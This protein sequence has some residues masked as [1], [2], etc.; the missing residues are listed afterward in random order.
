[1]HF[2]QMKI[3]GHSSPTQ[4]ASTYDAAP[5]SDLGDKSNFELRNGSGY[6]E[7]DF[8]PSYSVEPEEQESRGSISSL[9]KRNESDF[10]DY[11]FLEGRIADAHDD[12]ERSISQEQAGFSSSSV[13]LDEKRDSLEPT[14]TSQ[15]QARCSSPSVTWDEKRETLEPTRQDFDYDGMAQEDNHNRPLES[16]SPHLD[17][18]TLSGKGS[19]FG[20]R[21]VQLC[22]QGVQDPES[23]DVPLDDIESEADNFMD[24]LNTIESE[25]ETD[26]DCRKKQEADYHP[27]LEEKGADDGVYEPIRHNSESR[28]SSSESNVVANS[29]LINGSCEPV[30]ISLTRKF[31][32]ATYSEKNEAEAEDEHNSVSQSSLQITDSHAN[33]NTDAGNHV[34]SISS[35]IPSNFRGDRPGISITDGTRSTPDTFKQAPE[36]SNVTSVTFWTNGGLLG[37]QPSKPPDFSVLNAPPLDPECKKDGKI[38]LGNQ[39]FTLSNEDSGKQ[40]QWE[41]FKN[42]EEGIDNDS[43]NCHEY[44]ETGASF[45]KTSWKISPADLDINLG[46]LVTSLNQNNVNST[47]SNVRSSGGFLPANPAF[48]ADGKHQENTRTSSQMFDLSSRLLSTG[49]NKK[50][51]PGGDGNTYPRPGGHYSGRKGLFGGEFPILSPPSSPPLQHMK[52]SFQPID[53]FESSKLKLKFPDRNTNNESGI[54]IF[55]SFQLVPDVS[56]ARYNVGL[57]SDADTFY[58]SS[59]SLSDDCHSNQSE[60]NSEQWESSGSPTKDHDLYDSL[61]RISLTES[62]STLPENGRINHDKFGLQFL[63]NGV[64]NSESRSS[65]DLQSLG[66]INHSFRKELRN[67]I[68]SKDLVEPQGVTASVLPPLPPVQWRGTSTTPH[69]NSIEDMGSTISEGSYYAAADLTHSASTVSQPKPAPFYEDQTDTTNVQKRKQ[70]ISHKSNGQREANQGKSIDETDF[71]HQIRTKSFNLR[72]IGTIKPT[73]PSGASAA[74]QVT[75]ILEKANAIRQAVGSDGED[76][77]NW[78]DT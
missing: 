9:A 69:L 49:S 58:R 42:V 19:D 48:H 20:T 32:N 5:R 40:D 63:D 22:N 64:Q 51:L 55:P 16:F 11:N 43:S 61:R 66:S 72:P 74:V 37:L 3:G 14:N 1:M 23:G 45:R 6:I 59:P 27:K 39:N 73:L 67:D 77:G 2:T 31:P 4:T 62:V 28:S 15:E 46:K 35:A 33:A 44:Q 25:S 8:R 65:F 54:D 47:G 10:L 75:A 26:I 36:T 76:D 21:D 17:L 60:S 34:E 57:D 18:E 68:N 29:P 12:I 41:N 53:G 70:S 38:S 52:I 7:G 30:P 50:L 71:L 78:S 56:I 24:A 13:T